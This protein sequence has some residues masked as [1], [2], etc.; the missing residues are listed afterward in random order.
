MPAL[1]ESARAFGLRFSIDT[2]FD[3]YMRPVLAVIEERV[4]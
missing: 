2:V 1:G 3:Q 4:A